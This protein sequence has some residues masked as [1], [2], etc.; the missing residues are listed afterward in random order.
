MSRYYNMTMT[1]LVSL[2]NRKEKEIDKLLRK[3]LYND[4]IR[5]VR[6]KEH[7]VLINAEIASRVAQLPLF[8]GCDEN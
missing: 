5:A 1:E 6:L 8:G 7:V 2:K 4:K 3:G